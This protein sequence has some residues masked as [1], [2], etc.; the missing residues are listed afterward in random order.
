MV[1]PIVFIDSVTAVMECDLLQS[2]TAAKK[3]AETF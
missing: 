1:Y 2:Y 3:S